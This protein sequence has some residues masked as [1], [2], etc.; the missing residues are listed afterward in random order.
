MILLTSPS[1]Q[2]VYR[3]THKPAL[4]R[5]HSEIHDDGVFAWLPQETIL[6]G[7]SHYRSHNHFH[8]SPEASLVYWDTFVFGR[9]SIGETLGEASLQNRLIIDVDGKPMVNDGFR[10]AAGDDLLESPL[11]LGAQT[12]YGQLYICGPQVSAWAA[13]LDHS[14]HGHSSWTAYDNVFSARILG[15]HAYD[16]RDWL[17]VFVE[18]FFAYSAIH[19]YQ[20]PRIWAC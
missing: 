8:L 2:K 18:S 20:Q 14:R 10:L 13:K 5:S 17:H 4:V 15:S 19:S 16:L 7:G 3:S 12:C 9:P 1:A 11:G 6:F